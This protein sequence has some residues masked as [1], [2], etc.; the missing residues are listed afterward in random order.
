MLKVAGSWLQQEQSKTAWGPKSIR[1]LAESLLVVV[2]A[3][4]LNLLKAPRTYK[5]R[6]VEGFLRVSGYAKCWI[7][8]FLFSASCE[9][10]T[11]STDVQ[12]KKLSLSEIRQSAQGLWAMSWV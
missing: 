5:S 2:L 4:G 1:G 12:R 9:G 6:F 8:T 3:H 7:C 10:G 11:V